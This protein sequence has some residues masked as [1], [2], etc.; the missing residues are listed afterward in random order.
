MNSD[1]LK[2]YRAV[3]GDDHFLWR[4]EAATWVIGVLYEPWIASVV[5]HEVVDSIVLDGDA[6]DTT[7]VTDEQIID[8]IQSLPTQSAPDDDKEL[9]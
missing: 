6:V 4:I 9:A 5:A 1:L 2:I 7:Q 3:K 8:A